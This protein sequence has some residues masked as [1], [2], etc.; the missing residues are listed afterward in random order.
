MSIA[1]GLVQ[2]NAEV[3]ASLVIAQL[4]K[5]G[6][7]II[8]KGRLSVMDPRSGLS[9]WGNPEIGLISAATVEIGHYYGMP[10]D[11]YGLCTNAHTIDV[12]NGYERTLNA[13]LPVL[14]G[15]DEIS[16]IG[17]MDGGPQ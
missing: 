12:Q 15:A 1:G 8:Y 14:A 13:L 3:L 6:L 5:P 16:G 7:P 17:E 4:V 11:V 2:Q 9:V 10:V